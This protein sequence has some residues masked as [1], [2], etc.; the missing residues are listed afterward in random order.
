MP[1]NW[2]LRTVVLE[3]T[4]ESLLGSKE[5][6]QVNNK[7]DQSWIFTG[8]TDAKAE[9][10]VLWPPDMKSQHTGKDLDAGKDWGQEKR[11]GSKNEMA[12]WHHWWN[13]HE[14]GQTP[15]N[16]EGKGGLAC[17]SPCGHKESGI[18]TTTPGLALNSKT[19]YKA[20]NFNESQPC[21]GEGICITQWTYESYHAGP[22]KTDGSQWRVLTKHGPLE[23]GMANHSSIL[24]MRIP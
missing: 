11:G 16:G 24:A 12:G 13:E 21:Y 5:I 20:F 23:E 22:P 10:P 14:V 2:Y 8:R 17:C 6:K 4:L 7:G 19:K 9:A 3:K 18:T 1:K 15:G